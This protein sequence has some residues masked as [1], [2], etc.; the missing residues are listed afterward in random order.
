[1]DFYDIK[2][3]FVKNGVYEVYPDFKVCRS[4]DLMV[5]GKSFYAIWDKTVGLWN[6]DEYEVAKLVDEDIE[7]YVSKMRETK[8]ATINDKL[9]LNFSSNSWNTFKKYLT[10]IADS[11]K[12]LDNKITFA[13]TEVKRSDYVSK[14]LPYNLDEGDHTAYDK[15]MNTLYAEE[16]RD[17]LEWAIG[18]IVAGDSINIQ[19]FIVLYGKPGTGKST[20]INIIQD[21]FK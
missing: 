20:I 17:K 2:E 3:K 21:L 6:T 11:N 15:I 12:T 13:N 18:S 9:M 10:Q 16:E 14:R 19:K 4:R 1:M 5:R 7:K 8:N